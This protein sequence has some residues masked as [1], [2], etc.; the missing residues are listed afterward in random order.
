MKQIYAQIDQINLGYSLCDNRIVKLTSRGKHQ[1]LLDSML[2]CKSIIQ[3]KRFILKLVP[4]WPGRRQGQMTS[5]QKKNAKKFRYF[6]IKYTNLNQ[7]NQKRMVQ[8][9]QIANK[10]NL[11]VRKLKSLSLSSCIN[12]V[13]QMPQIM[14]LGQ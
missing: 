1:Q 6:K 14:Y 3:L 10:Q 9:E 7:L 13:Y 5:A 11:N 8:D 12:N 4:Q 2:K